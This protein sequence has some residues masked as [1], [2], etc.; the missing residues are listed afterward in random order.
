VNGG[1]L[2]ATDGKHFARLDYVDVRGKRVEKK[3]P[4]TRIFI[5]TQL[6]KVCSRSTATNSGQR[7]RVIE[8]L[9]DA[10]EFLAQRLL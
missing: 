10:R 4:A 2:Q 1:W 5:P 3:P 6:K 7:L 9:S 8:K